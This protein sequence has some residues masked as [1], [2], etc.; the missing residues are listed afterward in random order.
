MVSYIE[1]YGK[2]KSNF[3]LG[4]IIFTIALLLQSFTRA[5]LLLLVIAAQPTPSIYDITIIKLLGYN[6][7]YVIIP[8]V[9]EFI[10]LSILLYFTRE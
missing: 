2:L 5:I 1:I 9:L 8:D 10:A 4:L 3:T 7:V 6:P